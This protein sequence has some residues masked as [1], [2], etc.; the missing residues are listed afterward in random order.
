MTYLAPQEQRTFFVTAVTAGRKS[1]LQSSRMANLLTDVLQHYRQQA[2]FQLHEFVI[3]PNHLHAII[4][5]AHDLSLEKAMQFIKG[6][7]SFRAKRELGCQFEI[8]ER[9]FTEHRIKNC[10]DYEKHRLYV[11]E[12]PVCAGLST[13]AEAYPYSSA[14][15]ANPL[16]G[17]PPWLKPSSLSAGSQG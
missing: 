12:N 5:P 11:H 1:L 15:R 8:W 9:S 17:R 7:F 10:E 16:D 2:R 4:T 14:S 6:R 13:D 3:M